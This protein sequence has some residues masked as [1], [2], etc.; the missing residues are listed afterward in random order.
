M[1]DLHAM[2]IHNICQVI[3]GVSIRF[4]K[5]W[6]IVNTVDEIQL[7]VVLVIL[8]GFAINQIIE[9]GVFLYF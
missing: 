6:V 8:A 9:H 1:G 4:D 7:R 5:D 3:R 2:I